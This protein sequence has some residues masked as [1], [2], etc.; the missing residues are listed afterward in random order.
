MQEGAPGEGEGQQAYGAGPLL[1]LDRQIS[2]LRLRGAAGASRALPLRCQ[3]H[4]PEQA[5]SVPSSTGPLCL[6][7]MPLLK[8]PPGTKGL[9]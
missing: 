3:E 9:E 2:A 4:A 6:A 8:A 1:G 7:Y 5:G